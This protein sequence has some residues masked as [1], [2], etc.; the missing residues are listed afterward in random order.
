MAQTKSRYWCAVLYQENMRSDWREW[1]ED[2]LQLPLAYCE[3]TMDKD[4]DSDHR[5][6]HVHLI[7]A[8]PGPTT[9]KNAMEVFGLLSAPGRR[10]VNTCEA[11][12]N[13]RHMYDYLIH[14]TDACRAKGKYQY[15]VSARV[16]GNNFDI[17]AFEQ[18]SEV[19]KREI[20]TE[21]VSFIRDNGLTNFMDLYEMCSIQ[22]RS[23]D[24][25]DILRGN[26]TF[27]QRLLDGMWQRLRKEER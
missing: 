24:M 20:I 4:C 7:L 27:F 22:E 19:E 10:A 9:Y 8:W 14:D 12:I 13:M 18:L 17:G 25:I 21:M 11:V 15:P 5:K 1:I 6:D 26:S 3:H 2:G 23:V 16:L